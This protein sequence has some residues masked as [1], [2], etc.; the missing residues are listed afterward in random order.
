VGRLRKLHPPG[1]LAVDLDDLV[2]LTDA[3]ARSGALRK[4]L[5]TDRRPA[6]ADLDAHPHAE[7]FAA[8]DDLELILAILF[9]K[10]GVGIEAVEHA[11]D[12]GAD[13]FLGVDLLDVAVVDL[14]VDL[15]EKPDI[16]H[17][18]VIGILLRLCGGISDLGAEGKNGQQRQQYPKQ[19]TT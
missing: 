6:V 2:P 9:E 5:L 1:A 16:F 10:D 11:V 19:K 7:I 13:E 14:L 12:A 15:A 18:L 8:G 3:R 4:G 17:R